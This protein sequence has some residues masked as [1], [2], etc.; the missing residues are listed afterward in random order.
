MQM[1]QRDVPHTT[2]R[3]AAANNRITN[4]HEKTSL[5]PRAHVTVD[6]RACCS[7]AAQEGRELGIQHDKEAETGRSN[8]QSSGLRKRSNAVPLQHQETG[9]VK[10]AWTEN[11]HVD[12][13]E[14][15]SCSG[16]E[17]QALRADLNTPQ[18]GTVEIHPFQRLT[19][20]RETARL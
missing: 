4:E 18:E 5:A 6:Q 10:L 9:K 2:P 7:T 20:R 15:I 12:S 11:H 16:E 13:S 17:S 14:A 1:A 3:Q 19:V 8:S